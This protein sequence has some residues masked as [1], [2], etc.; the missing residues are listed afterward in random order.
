F[1]TH[2]YFDHV[3]G[4]NKLR[5]LTGAG[6]YAWEKEK[7]LCEDTGLNVSEMVG[8]PVTVTV[9]EYLKEDTLLNIEG[10]EIK[11]IATPGHTAGSC[12]Y[13]FEK[14]G[15]LISGDT[16]FEG[17]VGRTD[18]PTGS[19]ATLSRSLKEKLMCLSDEV[20][21]YPGHGGFTTIGDEKRY[22]PFCA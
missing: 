15:I 1:L 3:F 4:C 5:R 13:Y 21:V 18:F 19:A 2:A 8:R 11:L 9:D 16:L 6:V 14:D 22:N 17:S 12:C 20:K 7:P 10:I